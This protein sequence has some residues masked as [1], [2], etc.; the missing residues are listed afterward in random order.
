M[1]TQLLRQLLDGIPRVETAAGQ[2]VLRLA[3]A[4]W[5]ADPKATMTATQ[6]QW[7]LARL[8]NGGPVWRLFS[9]EEKR[10]FKAPLLTYIRDFHPKILETVAKQ[11][12][13]VL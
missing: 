4:M 1:S 7:V 5:Q 13:E 11:F 2:S 6:R 8:G 10:R 9:Q 3:L 12:E